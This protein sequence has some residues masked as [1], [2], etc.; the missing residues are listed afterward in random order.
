MTERTWEEEHD[1][2]HADMEGLVDEL[3]DALIGPEVFGGT[4]DLSKG[5]LG[6]FGV[7][8]GSVV[9]MSARMQQI[10]K[11]LED[12]LKIRFP[13]PELFKAT[14]ALLAMVTAALGLAAVIL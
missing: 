6:K 13:W 7:L 4:R 10:E 9:S 14:S 11:H 2:R 3:A 12:G 8:E 1:E 5:I